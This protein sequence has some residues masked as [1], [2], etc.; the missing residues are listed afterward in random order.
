[1]QH[2]ATRGG[3]PGGI[4]EPAR[5]KVNLTLEILGKRSDGYHELT[6]LIAFADV[7]DVVTFHPG[8]ETRVTVG[9]PMGGGLEQDTIIGKTLDAL[10]SSGVSLRLGTVHLDKHLP[11]AAGLGGGS[12]NAAAVLRA[13]ARENRRN[14]HLIDWQRIA[15]RL[16]A[17]VPVCFLNRAAWVTGI[18]ERL[19][20]LAVFKAL[21]VVLVNP[22]VPVPADKTADVFRRLAAGPVAAGRSSRS[23]PS[24]TALSDHKVLL[25]FLKSARNDLEAPARA[26]IP[27]IADVLTALADE[28]AL[29]ARMSGAG[30]TCFGVFPD[31][32]GAAAAE[33]IAAAHPSWWVRSTVLRSDSSSAAQQSG[34]QSIPQTGAGRLA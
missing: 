17:D 30:P 28:G 22:M 8:G 12:A 11:I 5:A 23:Q 21:P 2:D 19:V 6:S 7:G 27:Q 18:G 20:P 4:R 9:G 25:H 15:A 14:A 31:G 34:P 24:K 26:L 1:M 13:V 3:V 33:R 32:A 16:G 29:L 10:R